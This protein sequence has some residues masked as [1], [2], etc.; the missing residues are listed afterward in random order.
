MGRGPAQP[1]T[2]SKIHG[3]A[4]PGPSFFK[5]L[6]PARPGPA[7]HMAARP[8]RHGLYMGRPDNDV[9]RPVDLTGRPMSRP[10]CCPVQVCM[11]IRWCDFFTLIAVLS[12]FFPRLYSVGQLAHETHITSTHYSH[13]SAPPTTRWDSFLW[14]TTSCCCNA[15]SRSSS[16]NSSACC[17]NNTRC[18]YNTPCHTAATPSIEQR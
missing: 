18:C 15:R 5:S 9:G 1:I 12:L 4:R 8:M 17:C 10:M 2:F 16:N 6:G 7:H 11:C 14:T 13:N 3:R